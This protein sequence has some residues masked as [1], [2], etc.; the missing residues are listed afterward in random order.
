MSQSI[1]Y[2]LSQK[3]QTTLY[4][5]PKTIACPAPTSKI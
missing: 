5:D 4:F 1:Q 2:F 3:R